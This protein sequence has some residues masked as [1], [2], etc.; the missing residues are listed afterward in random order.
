MVSSDKPAVTASP[1]SRA[2][3]LRARSMLACSTLPKPWI[4]SGTRAIASMPVRLHASS[5]RSPRPTRSRYWIQHRDHRGRDDEVALVS[6][7]GPAALL[8]RPAV[9]TWRAAERLGNAGAVGA[10]GVRPAGANRAA[11]RKL[12]SRRYA[13]VNFAL[14]RVAASNVVATTEAPAKL[15]SLRLA[16]TMLACIRRAPSS[17]AESSRARGKLAPSSYTCAPDLLAERRSAS[18]KSAPRM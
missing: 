16:P 17:E 18:E 3:S 1:C 8:Q 2:H 13:L 10:C 11:V 4:V 15:V 9:R 5:A 12:A 14:F 7:R 6:Q